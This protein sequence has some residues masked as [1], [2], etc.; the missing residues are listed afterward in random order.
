MNVVVCLGCGAVPPTAPFLSKTISKQ[1]FDQLVKYLA[2]TNKLTSYNIPA[3]GTK[4]AFPCQDSAGVL[5][6]HTAEKL[7]SV[8]LHYSSLSL[9]TNVISKLLLENKSLDVQGFNQL[10]SK[11][12]RGSI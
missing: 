11:A 7:D 10:P 9:E 6:Y 8:Q 3:L 1:L 2:V 5:I 12:V 4:H